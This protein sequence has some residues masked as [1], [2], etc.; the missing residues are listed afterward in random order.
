[1]ATAYGAKALVRVGGGGPHLEV[2]E[3]AVG[4]P[5]QHDPAWQPYTGW[6][7][8]VT[9]AWQ[10]PALGGLEAAFG[11]LKANAPDANAGTQTVV[12]ANWCNFARAC[13][14]LRAAA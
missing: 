13:A 2:P 5:G 10:S 6:P 1:M 14:T 3:L 7:A 8:I 4:E 12:L 11:R 9:A